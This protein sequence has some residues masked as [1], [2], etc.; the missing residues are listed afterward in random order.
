MKPKQSIKQSGFTLIEMTVTIAIMAILATIVLANF[1]Q[2]NQN[3]AVAL[4]ADT[5]NSSFRTAQTLSLNPKV[6]NNSSCASPDNIPTEYHIKMDS[7]N[8]TSFNLFT[9]AKCNTNTPIVVQTFQLPQKV[10]IKQDG[11]SMITSTGTTLGVGSGGGTLEITF[12]PPFGKLKASVNGGTMQTFSQASI[13]L[14]SA[15]S[16]TISRRIILDGITGRVDS[17]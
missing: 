5:V 6:L 8:S 10:R 4:G 7:N 15:T 13:T 14:E 3:R 17:Q 1:K 2:G 11:L 9:Y 12:T 16:G